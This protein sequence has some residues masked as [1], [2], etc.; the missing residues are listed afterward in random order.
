MYG[1]IDSWRRHLALDGKELI[2][3]ALERAAG[4]RERLRRVSGLS[5][6][7]ESIH[8]LPGV[9]EWDPLKLSVDV[10]AWA[11]PGYHARSGCSRTAGSRSNSAT[12]DGWSAR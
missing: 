7:D 5:V 9:A 6:I 10:S 11:S 8:D 1:S 3:G 4:L 2:D 12:P